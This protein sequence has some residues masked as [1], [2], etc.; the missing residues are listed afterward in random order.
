MDDGD[1][2]V[3][4]TIFLSARRTAF[5]WMDGSL[6]A[7]EDFDRQTEDEQVWVA[8]A[9]T[10]VVGFIAIYLPEK[11]IHHLFVDPVHQGKGVGSELLD[12]ALRRLAVPVELKCPTRHVAGRR[13]YEQ[14]GWREAERAIDERMG[15]F[16]RYR[17][18]G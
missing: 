16:I 10:G 18:D 14:R 5:H 12:F 4:R 7:L 6:F 17:W 2:H 8:E 15:D 11:F 13:F 9:L 3:C 1:L